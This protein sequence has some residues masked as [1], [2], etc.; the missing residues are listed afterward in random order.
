VAILAAVSWQRMTELAFCLLQM[1][2]YPIYQHEL[3]EK[4]FLYYNSSQQALMIGPLQSGLLKVQRAS[5]AEPP[6]SLNYSLSQLYDFSAWKQWDPRQHQFF[7]NR[8]LSHMQPQCVDE[9]FGFCSSGFLYPTSLYALVPVL[10]RLS[11]STVGNYERVDLSRVYFTLLDGVFHDLRPVYKMVNE[12]QN[13]I[14]QSGT[15]QR[16]LYHKNG[17]WRVGAE[18]GSTDFR[19]GIFLE[20]EGNAMRVEYENE[21]EWQLV[22]ATSYSRAFGGLRCSRQ[23]PGDMNCEVGTVVACDNGGTCHTDA[24]GVSSCLCP[25]GYRGIQCKHRISECA[26]SLETPPPASFVFVN[27]ETHYDGSIMTVFCLLGEVQYSVCQNGSWHSTTE[28]S[29]PT[30]T[31]TTTT[32]LA[33]TTTWPPFIYDQSGATYD[34]KDSFGTVAT[35]V[36]VLVCIQLGCP[37]LCYCCAACCQSDDEHLDE[38]IPADDELKLDVQK[39]K[40]SLQRTFSGFFYVCWWA[41]LLFAIIYLVRYGDDPLDGSTIMSAVAIMAFVCLG[42]LY[43]G[44]VF[45]SLCSNEYKYLTQLENEEV[46]AG[47]QITEMK[48][49]K[50]TITFRAEC[51][52][53]ETRTRTVR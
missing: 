13:R 42:V 23:L 28:C 1:R 18:I 52:R 4:L 38:E 9:K 32:T 49:A 11:V 5:G 15:V 39:R 16:Y 8:N 10:I 34:S 2:G 40:A 21:T 36:V 6:S 41:W 14:V 48:A 7:E 45:E 33:T 44:V 35:V 53:N 37:F 25:A 31:T 30:T 46:T 20:L 3:D 26:T 50:P 24:D 27:P 43:C 17:K 19:S 12:D 51:S 29:A 22:G 47:E